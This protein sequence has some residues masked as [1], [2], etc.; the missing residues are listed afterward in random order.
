MPQF[1]KLFSISQWRYFS[2]QQVVD[3]IAKC[4]VVCANCHRLRTQSRR[5][6]GV[7][8]G[9]TPPDLKRPVGRPN[10]KIETAKQWLK[11]ALQ[12]GLPHSIKNLRKAAIAKTKVSSETLDRAREAI[13]CIALQVGSTWCWQINKSSRVEIRP[14]RVGIMHYTRGE[15]KAKTG[16]ERVS[17]LSPL[18][19]SS[20]VYSILPD[21][22]QIDLGYNSTCGGVQNSSTLDELEAV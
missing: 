19:S 13:G 20:S 7:P 10:Y 4:E 5:K 12:D 1:K 6:I 21:I 17:L 2:R 16:S 3:E 11:I 22:K 18:I 15:C 14:P 8:A 9:V